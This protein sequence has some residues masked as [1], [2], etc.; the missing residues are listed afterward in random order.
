M[1]QCKG[2]I[3]KRWLRPGLKVA[4]AMLLLLMVSCQEQTVL[5]DLPPETPDPKDSS[6][7]I[8]FESGFVDGRV[9]TRSESTLLEDYNTTMGVWGWRSNASVSNEATFINQCVS[10]NGSEWAYSPVKFWVAGSSYTF[11]AYSPYR[12]ENVSVN[13]GTGMISISGIQADGT[14]WMVSRGGYSV[15]R[16]TRGTVQLVMQHLLFSN[17]VRAR[18]SSQLAND[19]AVDSVTINNVV[20]T[21]FIA[22]AD[23]E[24]KLT[25]TPS[26]ETEWEEGHSEWKLNNTDKYTLLYNRGDTLS[27]E[28]LSLINELCIPQQLTSDM[29]LRVDWSIHYSDGRT[30]SYVFA[31]TLSNIFCDLPHQYFTGGNAYVISLTVGPE[32]IKF[33]SGVTEWTDDE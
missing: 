17:K 10:W 22:S 28:F 24:Q 25:H 19:P 4:S 27:T 5:V 15:L 11:Y 13:T 23:F 29:S 21:P 20:M 18:I 7:V 2:H 33:D 3:A 31:E 30:E 26:A 8:G 6:W 9:L 32:V 12:S 16:A 14:D 1:Q